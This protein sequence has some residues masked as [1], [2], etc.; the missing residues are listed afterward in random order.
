MKQVN[1][2]LFLLVCGVI[3]YTQAP[4]IE[5]QNTIGGGGTEQLYAIEQT[6]D[7]GYILGG[8]SGSNISGDKTEN[9][10]GLFDF[11]I[12][13]LNNS[14][15]IEWQNTIG[16]TSSDNLTSL[17]QTNDGGYIVGGYSQSGIS[18]DKNEANIG[19]DDYWILKLDSLGNIEWQNTIG[20]TS[21]DKLRSL[22]E[23]SDGGYIAGGT[24]ESIISGDK[25]EDS[26]GL[27]DYWIIK[28]DSLGNIEWQNTI[29]GN[30]SE[31]QNGLK[32]TNGGEYLVGGS[33]NS[34]ISGDKN[35]AS[36]E[37]PLGNNTSD[38]W[39]LKISNIGVVEWQTT[40]G[41]NSEDNLRSV[42]LSTDG[43]YGLL[44]G[45]SLS[46]VS[47]DK[48]TENFGDTDYW[49]ISLDSL[50]EIEWQKGFG[51]NSSDEFQSFYKTFENGH[52]MCGY[53]L[54]GMT[55]NKSEPNY[56]MEDYW[57]IRIDSSGNILWQNTLQG[58]DQDRAN[59]ILQTFEG[60]YLV[61]GH[62]GS[63][64]S[65]DKTEDNIGNG[66][67]WVVKFFPEDCFVSVFYQD[68]DEDGYGNSE[69]STL[70][71]DIP[72]GYVTNN[73]DCDD[74]NEL[75]FPSA[76]DICNSI[77]DNCN[78]FL[79]EDALFTFYYQDSDGDNFGTSLVD[80]LACSEVIGFVIDNSD[81]DD[82][83]FDINPGSIEI[84]NEID[85]NCNL[86][87]DEGLP[88]FEYYLDM[89]E[90]GYGTPDFSIEVCFD[91]LPLGY[92][93]D[94]TDCNDN[95]SAIFPGSPELLNGLD[96]NC[97]EVIDEGFNAVENLAAS[98]LKI[99]PNPN[100]GSFQILLLNQEVGLK[101]VEIFTLIGEIIYSEMFF[102]NEEINI[103]LPQSFSGVG[104]VKIRTNNNLLI[105]F[106][107]VI[108]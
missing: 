105:A 48:I 23:T 69:D 8:N 2:F 18:G 1:T 4:E 84:C 45:S 92:V 59:I 57:I 7:G 78:G 10:I 43:S 96:D 36:I 89:D 98:Q 19:S 41:G 24:S 25:T 62:S 68:F 75:I 53:S 21:S 94:S 3:S 27:Q 56:G 77:D 97:N 100:N 71:C 28:I 15:T 31:A 74:S 12:V 50:G 46:G 20:G 99:F 9:C 44:G 39:I 79:D 33:S 87:I 51:G 72:I 42:S 93:A 55:G 54:S 102:S 47:A 11:W 66:D 61:G 16:G 106:I 63:N 40:V 22:I 103:N 17:S 101:T 95:N 80:S 65:P 38:Y 6:A 35:E 83:N 70:A 60:G 104:I 32:Q 30:A 107:D 108:K 52:I 37:N 91:T 90:D 82:S 64:I 76:I 29:G 34:D 86:S 49:I 88:L 67:F 85:D 58:N 13:K 14:G 26:E 5:W 81:C 73:T